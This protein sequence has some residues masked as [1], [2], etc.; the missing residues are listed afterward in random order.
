M[1]AQA[2]VLILMAALATA[3]PAGAVEVHSVQPAVAAVC[4]KTRTPVQLDG[5]LDEAAWE[6]AIAISG[7]TISGSGE[8]ADNQTSMR[9][10]RDDAALYFGVRCQEARMNSIKA[11]ES[12]R[13]APVWHDDCVEVFIDTA[14]DHEHFL[15]FAV[16]SIAARFDS[17]TG[18]GTW[19]AEWEAAASRDETGWS[20]ELRIPFASMGVEPPAQGSVWGLNVCRE[21]LATGT[22][23]LHNWANVQ[24][25][26]L[27]PWLFGHLYMAGEKFDL[28]PALASKL[29]AAMQ[30]PLRLY[31]RGGYVLIGAQG[32]QERQEYRR[33]LAES[34]AQAGDLVKIRE[35]LM[36]TYVT[37]PD[38]PYVEDFQRIDAQFR[39]LQT[40]ATSPGPLPPLVW[41]QQSVQIGRLAK[42]MSDLSWKV[43]IAMLLREA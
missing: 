1:K 21:R 34:F 11:D 17:K 32:I 27:R 6:Q 35:E 16:N 13:D 25:N 4:L 28:T 29:Y 19:D 15:Q 7:F 24:G 40:A 43:K 14:H 36:R 33:L 38:A 3:L 18:A 2:T 31:V 9:V 22:R 20:V 39:R 8:P 42:E 10:L 12:G 30:V 41:A 5:H 37:A 23:E 26:F